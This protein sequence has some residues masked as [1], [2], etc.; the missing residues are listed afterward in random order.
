RAYDLKVYGFQAGDYTVSV[1]YVRGVPPNPPPEIDISV[2]ATTVALGNPVTVTVSATDP[3]GVLLVS[4]MVSSPWP[5]EWG[6]AS[7]NSQYEDII[8]YV[9]SFDE[10]ASLTFVPG[11]AGTYTVEAWACDELGN[12][13][14]EAVPVTDTFV[15]SE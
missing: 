7:S 11:W 5:E 8:E 10:E 4:F 3:D 6:S 14:P 15:V 2:P 12:R 13:T 1:S 9:M